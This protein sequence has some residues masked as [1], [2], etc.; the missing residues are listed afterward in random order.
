MAVSE[1][2]T[3]Q[4]EI[5]EEIGPFPN[6]ST[7]IIESEEIQVPSTSS[8]LPSHPEEK[9]SCS[10]TPNT[11]GNDVG[12][13]GALTKEDIDFWVQEGPTACQHHNSEFLN[14]VR[15]YKHQRRYFSKAFL[16]RKLKSDEV[17]LREWLLYSPSVG[18]VYCFPCILFSTSKCFFGDVNIGFNDW[19]HAESFLSSHEQSKGH[20]DA[21]LILVTR[22][23][24]AGKIDA[25]SQRYW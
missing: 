1:Q 12:R 14:S 23:S 6:D 22:R 16:Y 9:P 20:R 8:T 3:D 25:E 10:K 19:K 21:M 4:E 5:L 15:Q 7:V 13:W 18:K 2:S 11:R 17:I 24:T